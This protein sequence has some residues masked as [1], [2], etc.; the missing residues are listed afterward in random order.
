MKKLS[1]LL[2]SLLFVLAVNVGHSDA[3]PEIRGQYS[4]T[5]STVVSNCSD[6]ESNGTF[7]AVLEMNISTQ[8][9]NTFSGSATGTF[10]LD[11]LTAVEYIQLSGT[12]TET[13][14]IS[15]STS[16]TFLGT[17]GE[18]TFTG[19]LSGN[20]LSIENPGHDTYGDTCNYIRTMSATRG[21]YN[22][23]K[24]ST[25]NCNDESPQIN[26]IGHVVWSGIVCSG[27]YPEIFL[28]D[29][30][31]TTQLTNKRHSDPYYYRSPQIN[32]IGHVVWSGQEFYGS[33]HEIFLYD[34]TTTIQLTNNGYDDL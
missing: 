10:D 13:G 33:D 28:Y 34:G 31:T 21:K 23:T 7:N 18:G 1:L 15:G 3:A 32:S 8:T 16:H 17:R 12:I 25:S 30:T 29:G 14:Q 2:M 9:G 26:S 24:I 20:T 6:S 19:R 27:V 22:I 5:Y 11:G 4:G